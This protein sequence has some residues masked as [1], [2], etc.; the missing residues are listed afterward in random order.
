MSPLDIET[1]ASLAL[2]CLGFGWV[3]GFKLLSFKKFVEVSTH[4]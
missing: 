4:G 3:L 1:L 2:G